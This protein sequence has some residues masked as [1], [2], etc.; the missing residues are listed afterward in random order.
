M[1]LNVLLMN[2]YFGPLWWAEKVVYD[3]KELLEKNIHSVRVFWW[4]K[5]TAFSFIDRYFSLKFFWLAYKKIKK[6]SIDII[7]IHNCARIISP[8]PIIAWKLLWKR[9][10]MTLHDFHYYCPKSWWILWNWKVCTIWYNATCYLRN[11]NTI[12]KWLRYIPYQ[13]LRRLKVW[14][15]R[16]IIKQYVDTFISP[17]STL[18]DYMIKSLWISPERIVHI[19]NFINI[20]VDHKPNYNNYDGKRFLYVWRISLE[21]WVAVVIKAFEQLI[22]QQWVSDIYL[23]I[24]WDWPEKNTLTKMVEYLWL[25]KNI[26][27]LWK[28]DNNKLK[29]YYEGAWTI[30]IPSVCQDN[31][32]LVAIEAMKFWRP[33]IASNIWW[34]PDLV[35]NDINWYLF[36]M[37][38]YK[39]LAEKILKIYGKDDKIAEM[40]KNGF[41]KLKNEYNSDLFYEKLMKVYTGS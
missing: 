25:Q 32:P 36:E 29:D 28:I 3:T 24:I 33:I 2:D 18:K 7:H 11:C 19:P 23:D 14:I 15:H 39:D 21:K 20:P 10:V 22:K 37:G 41:N 35:H 9:V 1:K 31:N 8:S 30:I 6:E 34:I 38:N 26:N 13:F 5:E 17:S 4:V 40:W 12:K 27:F 16:F